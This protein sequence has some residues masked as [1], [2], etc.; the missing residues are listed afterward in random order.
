MKKIGIFSGTFDPIHA[1]HV[2]FASAVLKRY[3]LDKIFFLVEPRPRRKQGV[4][5]FEHR[6]AMVR[7][8]LKNTPKMGTIILGQAR[9]SPHETLPLLKARF[10]GAELHMLMGEDML[11]HLA[12]WPH[13]NDLVQEVHFIIGVRRQSVA[14]TKELLR[15]LEQTRGLRLRYIVFE[16]RD[17][18]ISSS[19]ARRA[20]RKGHIPEGLDSEVLDYIQRHKLYTPPTD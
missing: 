19:T 17:A 8:A 11:N 2:S 18:T 15:G 14:D 6:I 16:A 3:Q 5:A 1:G 9:F 7:I 12:D 13:I 4:K 10:K 20:L